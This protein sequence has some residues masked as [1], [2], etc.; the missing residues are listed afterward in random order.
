[1]I[2]KPLEKFIPKDEEAIAKEL[3]PKLS[4]RDYLAV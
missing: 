1:V 3:I 2:E 4:V